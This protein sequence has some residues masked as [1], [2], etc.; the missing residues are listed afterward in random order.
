MGFALG[1]NT[2]RYLCAVICG[3]YVLCAVRHL[4]VTLYAY[5]ACCML[6]Y[7]RLPEATAGYVMLYRGAL[8]HVMMRPDRL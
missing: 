1:P 7:D 3:V 8:C 5:A 2:V 6:L 4:C